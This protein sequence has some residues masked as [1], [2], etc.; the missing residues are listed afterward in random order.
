MRQYE[1][2]S[3]AAIK[4]AWGEDDDDLMKRDNDVA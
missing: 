2:S 3:G 4:G 1:K